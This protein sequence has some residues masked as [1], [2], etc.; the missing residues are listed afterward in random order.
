M[1]HL[2]VM[3]AGLD[4]RNLKFGCRVKRLLS[5]RSLTHHENEN[6]EKWRK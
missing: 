2:V 5:L 4:A 6:K 3:T 1:S